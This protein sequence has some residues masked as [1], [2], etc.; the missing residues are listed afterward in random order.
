MKPL[1]VLLLAALASAG[2][3]ARGDLS[4]EDLQRVRGITAPTRDFSAPE[5]FEAMQ[6]GAATVKKLINADV[7]SHASANL[8]FEGRQQFLVG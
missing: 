3:S 8:S 6:A 2:A 1:A 5:A 4:A 7:F